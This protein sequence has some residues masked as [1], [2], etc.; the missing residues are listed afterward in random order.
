VA[1][2]KRPK[3][4]YD[5]LRRMAGADLTLQ[6]RAV[7]I[8]QYSHADK[9]GQNSYPS[10]ETLASDLGVT[11]RYVS[12]IRASLVAK[13]WLVETRRGRNVG[14]GPDRSSRFDIVIPT[15]T[16]VPVATGTDSANPQFATGTIVPPTYPTCTGSKTPGTKVGNGQR[17]NARPGNCSE[18]GRPEPS[19]DY[20]CPQSCWG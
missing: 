3:D 10:L 15:G 8:A 2:R 5:L 4:V 1:E 20:S 17:A 12:K 14:S 6:E 18:C 9:D 16:I 7:L 19:H 13:G 11:A